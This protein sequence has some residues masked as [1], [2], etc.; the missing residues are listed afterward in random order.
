MLVDVSQVTDPALPWW[1]RLDPE[2]VALRRA[3]RAAVVIPLAFLFAQ[4]VLGNP[5][6][7]IFVVFGC[8]ALLVMADFSGSGRARSLAY[9]GA[10][11]AGAVLVALGTLVSATPATAAGAMLL[12][13]F[14]L[15]FAGVF[16]GYLAAAQTGLLLA[17]VISVSLPAPVS[18]VPGRVGGW[19]LAGLIATLAA[20]FLWPRP[21]RSD[22]PARVAQA[23]LAVAMVVSRPPATSIREARE[24]VGAARDVYSAAARRPAGLI[25]RDRAY[26]EVFSELGQIIDLVESPFHAH[27]APARPGTEE[28]EALAASVLEALRASA[29]FLE[30]GAEPDLGAVDQAR[31]LH[32]AALD[33]WAAEQLRGGRPGEEI[34]DGLDYDHTLRVISYL[35]IGLAGNAVIAAGGRLETE[36]PLPAAI[37]RRGGARG[38]AARV[39]RTLRTHLEPRSPVLHNSLRLAIGLAVAVYLARILGLSHAFWVVLGALQ[40][41]RTSVL[42]TGRTAFRALAGNA[43]GVA[44]GGLFAALAGRNPLLMWIALPF[45]IFLAAYAATTVGFA[46]S[47]AAFTV[48]LII[49]FN[50][51]SPA[52]WQVGLLRIED[53]AVGAAISVGA[54]LLL[55]PRGARQDLARSVSSFYRATAAYLGLAFDRVLGFEVAGVSDGLRRQAVR[56]RDRAGESLQVLLSERSATHLEPRIAA[57]LVTAGNQGMLAADALTV[58]ATDLGYRAGA[59]V[60]GATAIRV[61]VRALL[62]QLTSLADCL[63]VGRTAP[64][65]AEPISAQALRAAALAC[66]ERGDQVPDANRSAQALVIAGEWAQNLARLEADL[67]QPVSAAV[68]AARIPWWR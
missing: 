43:L 24:A 53:V 3:A 49:V 34:L 7:L 22:L 26:F 37:P 30:G 29:A 45:A 55:W 56:A 42:G 8:F 36:V 50:L 33:R 5:Q 11:L 2:L 32:R 67:D 10:V 57:A 12:V 13:G 44:V 27:P 38:A 66:L 59:C 68:T 40:V 58:V 25:R 17:F 62:A 16:G 1:R 20:G 6:T 31:S 9:L 4:L 60:E 51:I 52:G 48:N 28:G 54:G 18:A 46:L 41:L 14:A 23:V 61:Q 39:M 47:Q 65:K 35:A 19:M 64:G 21:A 63:E 15:A